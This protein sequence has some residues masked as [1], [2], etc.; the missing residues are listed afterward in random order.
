MEIISN[1]E[2][3]MAFGLNLRNIRKAKN[4]KQ[5]HVAERCGIHKNNYTNI[6]RGKRN[7]TISKAKAIATALDVPLDQLFKF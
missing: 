4:L 5:Y 1:K 3:L 2:F 7:I 6:E